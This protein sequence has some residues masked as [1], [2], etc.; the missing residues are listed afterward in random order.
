ME[1]L[2]LLN[3]HELKHDIEFLNMATELRHQ[4]T[5]GDKKALKFMKLK[6]KHET[7]YEAEMQKEEEEIARIN[8]L[9]AGQD[10]NEDTARPSLFFVVDYLANY[11]VRFLPTAKCLGCNEKL[12]VPL[13]NGIKEDEMR[14]EKSY[15]MHWMHYSCFEKFVNEPPFLRKCPME[16]CN[17]KFGSINFKV[18]EITYKSREK[19]YMQVEQK[20]GEE[21]DMYRLL[22][23]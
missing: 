10:L 12:V 3:R 20:M 5:D 13:A 7:K 18:D 16:N 21:D 2:K 22:G 15:C 1:K 6:M 4:A 19:A 8:D 17:S 14:P 23:M 9:S 11:F